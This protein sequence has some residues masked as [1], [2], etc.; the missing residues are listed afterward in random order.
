[1][2]RARQRLRIKEEILFWCGSCGN[3]VMTA[4]AIDSLL[5]S[6]YGTF[7]CT[8]PSSGLPE[9]CATALVGECR[10]FLLIQRE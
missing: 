2:E 5:A 3:E 8:A 1:M 9:A 4:G 10:R 6:L 7:L